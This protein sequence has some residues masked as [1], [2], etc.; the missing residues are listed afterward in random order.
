MSVAKTPAPHLNE[1]DSSAQPTNSQSGPSASQ[2]LV[3]PEKDFAGRSYSF[4]LDNHIQLVPSADYVIDPASTYSSH[5]LPV[6]NLNIEDVQKF[7]M[8]Q[9]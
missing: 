7:K 1:V 6:P 4:S 2:N 5:E 3:S 9:A 8:A